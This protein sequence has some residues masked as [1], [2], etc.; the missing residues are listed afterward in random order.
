MVTCLLC[1]KSFKS[2]RGLSL[3]LTRT[4][5]IHG[6]HDR[7][8]LNTIQKF[9]PLITKKRWAKA[10]R[11]L[12]TKMEN[13]GDDEWM[14]GYLHALNGMIIAL[15]SSYSKPEPF[16]VNLKEFSKKNIQEI[17]SKFNNLSKTLNNQNLFDSAYF[18]AWKDFTTYI[19]DIQN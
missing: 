7:L 19:L 1:K 10:E 16:I 9:F 5:N 2:Q 8:S 12:K 14:Q 18:Q 15:K 17:K 6:S 3:H 13:A 4:H 11:Q